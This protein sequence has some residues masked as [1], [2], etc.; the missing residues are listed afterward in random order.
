MSLL[1]SDLR[2]EVD[3]VHAQLSILVR[4]YLNERRPSRG[5]KYLIIRYPKKVL[6]IF[7]RLISRINTALRSRKSRLKNINNPR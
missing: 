2:D 6:Q 3:A 7:Y 1:P 4:D 5:K